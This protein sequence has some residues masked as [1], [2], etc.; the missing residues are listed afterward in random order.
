LYS[1]VKK[2]I[3]NENI[4]SPKVINLSNIFYQNKEPM[5]VDP[6]HYNERANCL[7][8]EKIHELIPSALD[9]KIE[10]MMS[11]ST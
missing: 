5:Y 3:K 7:I 10:T 4:L 8:A 2:I 1:C 9:D 11:E 6:W